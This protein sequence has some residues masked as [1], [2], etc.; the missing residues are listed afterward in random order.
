MAADKFDIPPLK[1]LARSRLINWILYFAVQSPSVTQDIWCTIPP[2]E[3]E[4]RVAITTGISNQAQEFL[5]NNEGVE[6]LKDTS[7]LSVKVLTRIVDQNA[8]LKTKLE[9]LQVQLNN[10]PRKVQFNKPRRR[11]GEW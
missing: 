7:E 4:I 6:V 9:E 11:P 1:N 8:R 10:Q 5:S 2:H 3:I